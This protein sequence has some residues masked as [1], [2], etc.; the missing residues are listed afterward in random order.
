MAD[1]EGSTSKKVFYRDSKGELHALKPGQENPDRKRERQREKTDEDRHYRTTSIRLY[2][3]ITALYL[4]RA[5]RL[6]QGPLA[7]GEVRRGA[8]TTSV[9]CR[10][11]APLCNRGMNRGPESG[12]ARRST[13]HSRAI[14]KV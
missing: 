12:A 4:W 8:H 11:H 3:T 1:A 13:K 14:K 9:A 2:F 5:S 7:Q 6:V 10:L